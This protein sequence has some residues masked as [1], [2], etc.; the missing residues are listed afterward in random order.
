[1]ARKYSGITLDG[2]DDA[3]AAAAAATEETRRLA[4]QAQQQLPAAIEMTQQSMAAAAE[5]IGALPDPSLRVLTGFALGVGV[6]LSIA[7]TPRLLTFAA[8]AT[9]VAMVVIL[10]TRDGST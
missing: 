6:G 1:M 4:H 3:R 5:S 2:M 8:L 9:G 7:G 10:A